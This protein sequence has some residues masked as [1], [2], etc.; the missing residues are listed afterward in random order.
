MQDHHVNGY[1]AFGS[2]TFSPSLVYA[3]S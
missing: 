2:E 1:E 3:K